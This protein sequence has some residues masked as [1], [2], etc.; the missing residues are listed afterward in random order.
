VK[1]LFFGL[2]LI[3][4]PPQK[5][6][7]GCILVQILPLSIPTCPHRP[8][9]SYQ[10]HPP[11]LVNLLEAWKLRSREMCS[12]P[13]LYS[14][15]ETYC[16]ISNADLA[17]LV[18]ARTH[19]TRFSSSILVAASLCHRAL[20]SLALLADSL[21]FLII[22]A[23]ESI[24]RTNTSVNSRVGTAPVLRFGSTAEQYVSFPRRQAHRVVSPLLRRLSA[25]GAAST[26]TTLRPHPSPAALPTHACSPTYACSSTCPRCCAAPPRLRLA[27]PLTRPRTS[28]EHRL[29]PIPRMPRPLAAVPL[30]ARFP[31]PMPIRLS[32]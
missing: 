17:V 31:L 21:S 8:S 25:P 18:S 2:F 26:P 7:D 9:P 10:Q 32:L 29:N 12:C 27:S 4:Q 11:S 14:R 22:P 20:A 13:R 19:P 16:P 5:D 23:A 1:L 28:D 6:F 24:S 3:T 30:Q 15:C